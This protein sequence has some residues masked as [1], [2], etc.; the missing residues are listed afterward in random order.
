[1]YRQLFKIFL[2]WG[3]LLFLVDII[4]S[5]IFTTLVLWLTGSESGYLLV[6]PFNFAFAWFAGYK[7]VKSSLH[8]NKIEKISRPFWTGIGVG[9]TTMLLSNLLY[10]FMSGNISFGSGILI[11]V[12]AG[13]GG[14]MAGSKR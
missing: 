12:A 11:A 2:I 10:F 5:I 3:A 6:L 13:F 4:L 1:M 9:F 7:A 14:R 8:I